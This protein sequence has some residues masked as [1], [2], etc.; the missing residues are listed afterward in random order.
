MTEER[1][2][3]P[4]WSRETPR[5]FWDPSR[6]LLKAHR[7]YGRAKGPLAPLTK[8][9]AVLRYRFW[10]V[11]TGCDLPLNVEIGG[12]LIMPHPNGIVVH[13]DARIGKNCLL[14]Q[15]VTLG[16]AG[17][18][19]KGAPTL[20]DGAD[21]SAGAKVLGPVTIGRRALVG[22]NAVVLQ[23]VPDGM[24]AVGIPARII[25]SKARAGESADQ[26]Q[27]AH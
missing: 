10:S 24:V 15:Q 7:D 9:W 6:K 14:G 20:L 1:D 21:V 3:P 25:S 26:G 8:R 19:K 18:G 12:G 17:G 2:A 27:Q 13:P 22:A 5:G 16:V 23:D 11:V 4:D